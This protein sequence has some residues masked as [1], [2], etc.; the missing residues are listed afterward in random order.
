MDR[1]VL[2]DA[3]VEMREVIPRMWWNLYQGC[4]QS[5]F[6][7]RQSFSLLNTYILSQNSAGIKPNDGSG[8]EV[9]LPE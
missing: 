3:L 9:D 7:A 6:D 4:L 2:E 8:P 1:K 5:G